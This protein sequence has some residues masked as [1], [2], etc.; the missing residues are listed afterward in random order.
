MDKPS[1]VGVSAVAGVFGQIA[2]TNIANNIKD[3]GYGP[4]NGFES[5]ILWL[6]GYDLPLFIP[7][8]LAVMVILMWFEVQKLEGRLAAAMIPAS[9]IDKID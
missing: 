3:A 5:F 7:I 4:S 8:A 6:Y 1:A 9:S 2:V